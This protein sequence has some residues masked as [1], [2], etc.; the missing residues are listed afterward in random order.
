ML[1]NIVEPDLAVF[2]EKDYQQLLVV[3]KM[4][5]ELHFPIRISAYPTV[6]ET[7]GLAMSS[8]NQYLSREQRKTAP[9]LYC[10]LRDAS[11]RIRCG[12]RNFPAISED[13]RVALDAQGFRVQYVGLTGSLRS[14]SAKNATELDSVIHL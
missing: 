7:D 12:D 5:S 9:S 6:P 3:R 13:A 14:A 11:D 8:R 10:T 2:G 1:F 4:A